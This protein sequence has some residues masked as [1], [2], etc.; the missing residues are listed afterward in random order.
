MRFSV[1][2]F[3]R[4]AG[5]EGWDFSCTD[6]RRICKISKQV[7]DV[8]WQQYDVHMATARC[9]RGWLAT[10]LRQ[11]QEQID[12][13]SLT[14]CEIVHQSCGRVETVLRPPKNRPKIAKKTCMCNV[15][16]AALWH[17][18]TLRIHTKVC[19]TK[20]SVLPQGWCETGL[21]LHHLRN[22]FS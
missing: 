2:H 21:T 13:N 8:A 14:T 20:L 17:L 1:V 19:C 11:M 3:C 12:S 5:E 6:Y 18:A 9:L 15:L 10:I 4:I 16:F 7:E 22:K